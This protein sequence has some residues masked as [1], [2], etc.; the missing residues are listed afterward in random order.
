MAKA[1]L[2]HLDP[3]AGN[4]VIDQFKNKT[5][6]IGGQKGVLRVRQHGIWLKLIHPGLEGGCT[7][8]GK[9]RLGRSFREVAMPG[10]TVSI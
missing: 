7:F 6:I 2:I 3:M 5:I 9:S 4:K 1:N 8:I 10:A